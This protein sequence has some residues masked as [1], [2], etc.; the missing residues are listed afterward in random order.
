MGG[1]ALLFLIPGG[2]LVRTAKILYGLLTL[3]C[4]AYD[5]FS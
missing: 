5:A 4:I 3:K 1:Q 2:T